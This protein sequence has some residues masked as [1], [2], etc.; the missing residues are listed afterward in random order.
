MSLP[1]DPND[2]GKIKKKVKNKSHMFK[3]NLE[4]I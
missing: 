3:I 1:L 4:S 2:L